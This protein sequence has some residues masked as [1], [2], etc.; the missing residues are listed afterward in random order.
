[1]SDLAF[2]GRKLS[3]MNAFRAA[4]HEATANPVWR[5]NV[6]KH[7]DRWNPYSMEGG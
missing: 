1:M 2:E 4:M 3:D 7:A 6:K 5:S